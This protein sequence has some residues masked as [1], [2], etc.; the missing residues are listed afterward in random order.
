[1]AMDFLLKVARLYYQENMNQQEIAD[2]LNISRVKVY[3]LLMKAREE[4][5][6][7]IELRAPQQDLSELEIKIER[8]FG[9]KQCIIIP[10]SDSTDIIYSGFGDA[11]IS[12][13]DRYFKKGMSIGVGWGKTIK[14]TVEKMNFAKK[15]NM[16]VFPVVGGS[17]LVYDDDD[18]HANSI[19]SLLAGKSGATGYILNCPAIIDSQAS[20]EVFL[21]E[22]IIKK[23]VD[24]FENLDL[25]IVPIGYIGPD[26]T[27]YKTRDIMAEDIEY[28]NSLGIVGDVNSNFIDVDG[29]P[30]PNKI[31]DRIINVT[32]ESLKKIKNTIAIC[33]GEKKIVATR[34]ALKTG[35]IDTLI[36]DTS[37]AEKLLLP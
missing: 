18:I 1:M 9:I 23:I 7:K 19:V 21:Q 3:R 17:G 12:V 29:N 37:I 33:N 36:T 15:Y 16:T 26:I 2:C 35:V 10:T 31:Q 5:I 22:S 8:S 32:L 4:G 24:Q 13:I 25:A 27:I 30:I 14:G 6:V 20:K 34:A 11:L 28:F